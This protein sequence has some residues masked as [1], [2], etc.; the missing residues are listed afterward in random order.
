MIP[1]LPST[2]HY[3]QWIS[4][5]IQNHEKCHIHHSHSLKHLKHC[6]IPCSQCTGWFLFRPPLWSDMCREKWAIWPQFWK[7]PNQ[8]A[9]MGSWPLF[10]SIIFYSYFDL[11]SSDNTNMKTILPD[12][13]GWGCWASSPRGC[14]TTA[15]TPS[16]RPSCPASSSSRPP[17]WRRP[18]RRA[19]SDCEA[20]TFPLLLLSS[21]P[22]PTI[23]TWGTPLPPSP[24]PPPTHPPCSWQSAGFDQQRN[25]VSNLHYR[26]QW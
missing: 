25:N 4:N 15:W 18:W 5:D 16:P 24:H 26:A 14:P 6:H 2:S 10:G 7:L 9:F 23:N 17:Q 13:W 20:S 22:P 1:Y 12:L 11:F 8:A 3:C 19:P 21:N